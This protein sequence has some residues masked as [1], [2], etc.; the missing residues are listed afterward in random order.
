MR[1][2]MGLGKFGEEGF[3]LGFQ[4]GD[5]ILVGRL[6]GGG[7]CFDKSDREQILVSHLRVSDDLA[8]IFADEFAE[9]FA[10]VPVFAL[11]VDNHSK[12]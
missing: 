1:V 10:S 9:V 6:D 12:V 3:D 8:S 2:I 5:A 7:C 11:R 4:L